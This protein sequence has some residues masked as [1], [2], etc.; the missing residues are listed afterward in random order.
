MPTLFHSS[1][2]WT[3]HP[4]HY[5]PGYRYIKPYR[6]GNTG[7]RNII[8]QYAVIN[9]A[10]CPVALQANTRLPYIPFSFFYSSFNPSSIACQAATGLLAKIVLICFAVSVAPSSIAF[11]FLPT[12]LADTNWRY[13]LI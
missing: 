1:I 6:P 13:S 7:Q 8:T 5:H 2:I 4:I 11:I 12:T 9:N 3:D 10:Q